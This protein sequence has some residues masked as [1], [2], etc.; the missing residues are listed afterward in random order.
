MV[1][2][3]VEG[4]ACAATTG[5]LGVNIKIRPRHALIPELIWAVRREILGRFAVGRLQVLLGETS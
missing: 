5:W 3:M 1:G 2:M 4:G